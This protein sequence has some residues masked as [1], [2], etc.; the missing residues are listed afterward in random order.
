MRDL[1][2]RVAANGRR[3]FHFKPPFLHFFILSTVFHTLLKIKTSNR[4]Y[5]LQNGSIQ[6]CHKFQENPP[7][8]TQLSSRTNFYFVHFH[9]K[10]YFLGLSIS[11]SCCCKWGPHAIKFGAE[12]TYMPSNF[13]RSSSDFK[14]ILMFMFH[15]SADVPG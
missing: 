3:S 1:K 8:F 2:S 12:C 6:L 13:L 14:F 5:M 11:N 7:I 10:F 9:P 15:E 4:K